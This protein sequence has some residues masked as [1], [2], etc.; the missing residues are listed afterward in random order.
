MPFTPGQLLQL[1]GDVVAYPEFVP[2]VSA[3]RVW[4]RAEPEPGVTSLDAEAGVRFAFLKEK[5]ATR[6]R[7]DVRDNS[8]EVSLLYGPFRRL[9]NTWHFHPDPAG[10]R[11]EFCIEYEFKSRLLDHL[12]AV[13]LNHAAERLIGC[14]EARAHA[15]YNQP[16]NA[17][18]VRA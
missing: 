16:G 15:L 11:I 10:T 13:N 8:I 4:N 2:W 14:F 3:M 1:V 6:V 17:Q 12:L 9:K 5:F 7:R 18:G